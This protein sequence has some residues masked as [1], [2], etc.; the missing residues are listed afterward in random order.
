MGEPIRLLRVLMVS[1]LILLGVKTIDFVTGNDALAEE[2]GSTSST[3]PQQATAP[4]TAPAAKTPDSKA[5]EAKQPES[6]APAAAAPADMS[7]AEMDVLQNLSTRRLEL[8]ERAR[9][10]D[11]RENLLKA[12]EQRVDERISELKGI[13]KNIQDLLQQRDQAQ[14]AQLASL[15]KVYENM[16]PADAARIFDKLDMAI[17]LPVAQKMK[18]AKIALVLAAMDADAA[19]RLTINLATHLNAASEPLPE[20]IV[21]PS[22]GAAQPGAA[23]TAPAAPAKGG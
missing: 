5:A 18:P 15:V 6:K 10:L 22:P 3:P 20:G 9:E 11:M 23:A 4:V 7:R 13:E 19:K 12:S 21:T 1:A 17:L 16:K 14:A 8:D 2:H